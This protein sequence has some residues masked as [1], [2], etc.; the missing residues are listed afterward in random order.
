M[1]VDYFKAYNDT[2]GHVRG[3]DCLRQV[4]GVIKESVSRPPDVAIRF[5]G[6][7]FVCLLLETDLEGAK[8]V[9]EQI[10]QSVKALSL[11]HSYS[12]KHRVVTLSVGVATTRCVKDGSPKEFVARADEQLY[13]A[14]TRGRN[15]V[16]AAQV[17]Q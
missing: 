10:R 9:A 11:S 14:K 16:V 6:E 8:I 7:E 4:A 12:K 2:Y 17:E 1:D 3:D 5:G 15:C 13:K